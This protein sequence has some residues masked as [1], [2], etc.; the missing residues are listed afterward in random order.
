M[1]TLPTVDE[2][3]DELDLS[4]SSR[5]NLERIRAAALSALEQRVG[6]IEDREVNA[7]R[8]FKALAYNVLI[9]GTDAHAKNYSLVL[10]GARAHEFL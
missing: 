1:P 6:A 9:G 5:G 2:V 3:R 7:E 8:F 4:A 10:I